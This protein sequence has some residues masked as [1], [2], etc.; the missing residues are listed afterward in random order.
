MWEMMKFL[1]SEGAL[2]LVV[3]VKVQRT[4]QLGKSA[5]K[6]ETAGMHAVQQK[7]QL[8]WVSRSCSK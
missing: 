1:D 5:T 8:G 2:Q 6:P 3:E 4:T 7:K